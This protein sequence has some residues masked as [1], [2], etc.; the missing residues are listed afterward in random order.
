MTAILGLAVK[1]FASQKGVYNERYTDGR[2][3]PIGGL[4]VNP[5]SLEGL[6]NDSEDDFRRLYGAIKAY[7]AQHKKFPD[8]RKL[9]AYTASWKPVDQVTEDTFT[10]TDY[11]KSD[12]AEAV[13]KEFPYQWRYLAPRPDG[14]DKPLILVAGERDIWVQTDALSRSQMKVFQ[15]GTFTTDPIGHILVL[16]SDGKVEKLSIDKQRVA[17]TGL[18]ETTLYYEGETGVPNSAQPAPSSKPARGTWGKDHE[19]APQ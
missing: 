13:R 9:I 3:I 4:M 16:W 19:P 1:H 18:N 8:P 11:M 17:S 5:N 7:A 6:E 10:S 12:N 14:T 2:L 15:D